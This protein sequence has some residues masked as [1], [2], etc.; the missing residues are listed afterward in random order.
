MGTGAIQ[1]YYGAGRGKTDAALGCALR[2]ASE[3]KTVVVIQFFKGKRDEHMAYMQRLEPEIRIFRFEKL[4]EN[5]NEITEEQ[6]AEERL[7]MKNGL[8]FAKKVLVT[9]ECSLL[10]LDEVLGLVDAGIITAEDLEA[11]LQARTEDTD[12]IMTGRVLTESVGAC[13]DAIYNIVSE[14]E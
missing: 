7:N 1:I 3:N 6:Q 9:G 14:K 13:A 11:V 10:I 2:A 4:E 8:N 12:I 5:Y